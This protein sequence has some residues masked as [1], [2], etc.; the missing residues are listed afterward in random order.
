[1]IE[2]G[3]RI[4]GC[5]GSQLVTEPRL[6]G[7]KGICE[8]PGGFIQCSAQHLVQELTSFDSHPRGT[9]NLSYIVH[10]KTKDHRIAKCCPTI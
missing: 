10:W 6:F 5:S 9:E 8:H 2:A 4:G 1:V 3:G 7:L